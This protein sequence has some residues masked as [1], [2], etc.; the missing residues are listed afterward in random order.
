MND[1]SVASG[2]PA[3]LRYELPVAEGSGP[4]LL[5]ELLQV[6]E[7]ELRTAGFPFD[8]ATLPGVPPDV[9][10]ETYAARGVEPPDELLTWFAWRN[11]QVRGAPALGWLLLASVRESVDLRAAVGEDEGDWFPWWVKLGAAGSSLSMDTR[12]L[13]PAPLLRIT[14]FD[15][16]PWV[17]RDHTDIRSLC[18][19][20]TWFIDA[21]RRGYHRWDPAVS[22]FR[23]EPPRDNSDLTRWSYI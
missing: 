7:W 2:L 13:D 19:A 1:A 10:R 22:R 3:I 17:D 14:D 20:V 11:G 12:D 18:T 4:Q 21:L 8:E 16:G 5:H 23:V 6:W 9:T 15:I